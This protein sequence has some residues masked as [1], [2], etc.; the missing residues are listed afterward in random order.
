MYISKVLGNNTSLG[1]HS[2]RGRFLSITDKGLRTAII[3]SY[4]NCGI[5]LL[6]IDFGN[7]VF[8]EVIESRRI[9]DSGEAFNGKVDLIKPEFITLRSNSI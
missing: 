3:I 9:V 1:S 7:I 6:R 5:K 8:N 2:V 4:E